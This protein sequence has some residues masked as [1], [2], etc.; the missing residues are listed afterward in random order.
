MDLEQRTELRIVVCDVVATGLPV[1]VDERVRPRHTD[2]VGDS[3]IA[4]LPSPNLQEQLL[5]LFTII[6]TAFR[7]GRRIYDVKHF[8]LFLLVETF[9]DDVVFARFFDADDV[10]Y[11][12]FESDFEW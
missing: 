7:Q 3:H 4:V 9:E 6:R 12:V 11:F 2:I 8:A 1:P 5:L 10:N